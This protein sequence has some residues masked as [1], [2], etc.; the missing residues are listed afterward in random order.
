MAT[1]TRPTFSEILSRVQADIDS[2]LPG[3]DSRLRRSLLNVVAYIVAG[4]AHGIY[5]FISW[6]SLQVFPDTSEVEFLNRWAAIWGIVRLPATKAAGH[7]TAAGENGTVITVGTELQRID[8]VMFVVTEE[9]TISA[10]TATVAVEASVA[11][12][13]GNT[14]EGIILSF[15]SPT[16][17]LNSDATVTIDALTDGGDEEEDAPFLVRL[18][19]RIQQPPHGGNENDYIQWALQNNGVTRAWV[20]PT[21]LGAGTVTVRFMMDD[22]YDDGIPESGDVTTVGDYIEARRP[23]TATVNVVAPV[24]EPLDF[25][26]ALIGTDSSDIRAAVELNLRDLILREAEPGGTL[27][28]SRINEAISLASGEF[29]HVMT[30]PSANVTESTGH[31]TTMGDITWV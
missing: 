3:A 29:D 13:N 19:D 18:L 21:E 28:L 2:R 23:I 31:I 30:V 16:D 24:P 25:T 6:I 5:G 15:V 7:V 1:F 26:I 10:G 27:R 14:D 11:G 22:L 4:V 9:A 17:G 8:D 20:Y 12:E